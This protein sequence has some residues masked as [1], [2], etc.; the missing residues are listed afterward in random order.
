MVSISWKV[1]RHT[2]PSCGYGYPLKRPIHLTSDTQ[3]KY[4]LW[5]Y[6]RS[7]SLQLATSARNKNTRTG[8]MDLKRNLH[9]SV[10]KYTS[11]KFYM[12]NTMIDIDIIRRQHSYISLYIIIANNL[13]KVNFS[14]MKKKTRAVP[15]RHTR[16]AATPP[17]SPS[18][19]HR[20]ASRCS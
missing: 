3:C 4:H 5:R 2:I 20:T 1:L 16:Y 13:A 9:K 8:P 19:G 15:Q 11:W 6:Q 12:C 14:V 7:R 10:P 17:P 18:P